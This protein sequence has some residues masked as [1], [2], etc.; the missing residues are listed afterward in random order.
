MATK[1]LPSLEGEVFL[2]IVRT[3]GSL[4]RPVEQLLNGQGLTFTQYNVLRILRG[5]GDAGATGREIA[6]RMI[7]AEPDMTRLLDRMEKGGLI[8]RCREAADR[9]CVTTRI[10]P[11]GLA[12][13]DALDQPVADLHREQLA[14]L[15]KAELKRLLAWLR[16][17]AAKTA[18]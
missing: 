7:N 15:T 10:T 8:S 5:A 14:R 2:G 4:V 9:R 3:A 13:A 6:A 1:R 12:M 18:P 16:K 11:A 17:A